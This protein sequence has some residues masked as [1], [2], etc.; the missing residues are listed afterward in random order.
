MRFLT[1][2]YYHHSGGVVG[3]A[4]V[5][6]VVVFVVVVVTNFNLGYNFKSTEANL[7]KLHT[8]VKYQKGY[9]LIN[10]HNSAM[11]F[12]KSMP[13]LRFEARFSVDYRGVNHCDKTLNLAITLNV[14]KQ[15]LLNFTHF[16]SI[17]RASI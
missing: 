13:L 9:N 17:R 7:V 6:V 4:V 5:V 14:Q 2:V 3:G 10:G 12:D 8:L 11:L 16:F 1:S 15:I